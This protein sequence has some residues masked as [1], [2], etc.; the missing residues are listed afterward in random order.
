MTNPRN[1][2]Q[3]LGGLRSCSD[4]EV[5]ACFHKMQDDPAADLSSYSAEAIAE[6]RKLAALVAEM[7]RVSGGNC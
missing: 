3:R 5:F 2:L 4:Q 7:K 6:A 1:L